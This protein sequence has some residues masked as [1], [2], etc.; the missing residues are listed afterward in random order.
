[1]ELHNKMYYIAS[2]LIFDV[3]TKQIHDLVF[4]NDLLD[5]LYSEL[6]TQKAPLVELRAHYLR[7]IFNHYA[8]YQKVP[9]LKYLSEKFNN[10][11]RAKL[12]LD[13]F[14]NENVGYLFDEMLTLE[15]ETAK[16]MQA[17]QAESGGT[18]GRGAPRGS[19]QGPPRGGPA[20]GGPGAGGPGRGGPPQGSPRGGP[21]R[22]RG[23][24]P[25]APRGG[26]GD[27]PGRGGPPRGRGGAQGGGPAPAP[28]SPRWSRSFDF[29]NELLAQLEGSVPASSPQTKYQE[30]IFKEGR[31]TMSAHVILGLLFR[32]W[33]SATLKD[34]FTQVDRFV[35]GCF[36]PWVNGEAFESRLKVI[37]A[38][39]MA[40]D[41]QWLWDESLPK[42][43]HLRRTTD[44][45]L[46]H[47]TT[48]TFRQNLNNPVAASITYPKLSVRFFKNFNL[49]LLILT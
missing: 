19:P 33:D 12:M 28:S 21:P 11:P 40:T 9:L 34:I 41:R 24:G 22:G 49:W 13:H 4:K 15:E 39:I 10:V 29:L 6:L 3:N 45:I 30:L 23:D 37:K 31:V 5:H 27:G 43:Q 25:G 7:E 32:G 18:P 35:D 8:K 48:G 26:R 16:E 46:K 36:Q 44:S 1:M 14:Y 47:F 17:K 20:R 38:I 2:Q 42:A